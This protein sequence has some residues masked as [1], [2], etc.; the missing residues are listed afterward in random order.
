MESRSSW[1]G[2]WEVDEPQRDSTF[3]T[4]C[5]DNIKTNELRFK[6]CPFQVLSDPRPVQFHAACAVRVGC[7]GR[8]SPVRQSTLRKA[9]GLTATLQSELIEI[10]RAFEPIAEC[11]KA[12]EGPS[13]E[14]GGRKRSLQ[15]LKRPAAQTAGPKPLVK[16]EQT[17]QQSRRTTR[18]DGSVE[19]VV[20]RIHEQGIFRRK[21]GALITKC[22]ERRDKKVQRLKGGKTI[23]TETLT[24]RKVTKR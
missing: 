13:D 3:C 22:T 8:Y 16:A 12:R 21:G 14:A 10:L 19:E 24:V 4:S 11:K 18:K 15:V 6:W 7:T 23:I 9:I 20:T 1:H 2:L 5:G 17:R